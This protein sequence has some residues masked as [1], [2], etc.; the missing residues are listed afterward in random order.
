MSKNVTFFSF[1]LS[2]FYK[3]GTIA[4]SRLSY[5]PIHSH[6]YLGQNEHDNYGVSA[7]K[8]VSVP[9]KFNDA[10]LFFSDV[11]FCLF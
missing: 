4:M 9:Y 5:G 2:F 10:E 6:C 3:L 1:V 7:Y 11:F 8:H